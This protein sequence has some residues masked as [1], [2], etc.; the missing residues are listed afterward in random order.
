MQQMAQPLQNKG[1]SAQSVITIAFLLFALAGGI[2]GFAV[3]TFNHNAQSKQQTNNNNTGGPKAAK[4]STPV[5]KP[6]PTATAV[7]TP[8][9][10]DTPL[11]S[12]SPPT[13]SVYGVYTYTLTARSQA[14]RLPVTADGITCHLALIKGT[15]HINETPLGKSQAPMQI[16][17]PQA[18]EIPTGQGLIYQNTPQTQ[19]CKN[20]VGT[21]TFTVNPALAPGTYY[22]VG[23]TDWA[24][25]YYNWSWGS[26]TIPKKP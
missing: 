10:L 17:T 16:D 13:N 15:P 25:I 3:G 5:A 14:T 7:A 12:Q 9:P 26:I 24:G 20:G 1:N 18:N 6:S 8:Q 2:M 23:I 11:A 22:T 4:T 21:W 19:P